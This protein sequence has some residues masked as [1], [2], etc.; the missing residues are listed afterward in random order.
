MS[1]EGKSTFSRVAVG[2]ILLT[3]LGAGYRWSSNRCVSFW[4]RHGAVIPECPDGEVRPVGQLDAWGLGRGKSGGVRVMAWGHYTSSR[5]DSDLT[6]PLRLSSVE[7]FVVDATG[8][9]LPL[10]PPKEWTRQDEGRAM[11]AGLVL[12]VDLHDGHHTLRAKL[13]TDLGPTTV[14]SPLSLFAP[15]R[16]HVVTDRPLYQPGDVVK[17]R[18]VAFRARD[19]APLE[20]RPGDFRVTSPEGELLLSESATSAR[21]GIAAGSF[22]LDRGAVSGRWRVQWHSGEQEGVAE[23][24]VKPFTLPRFRIDANASAPF[25]RPNDTPKL[26]GRVVY[27]SGAPVA[28]APIE[29]TW[30]VDGA[31]PP[32]RSWMERDLPKTAKADALG[33]FALTLPR[34]PGDLVGEATLYAALV[35]R[36]PNGDRIEGSAAFKLSRDGIHVETVTE[37]QDGLV[38]GFDNRLFV[39]ATTPDGSP[40]P[41]AAVRVRKAWDKK[42]KG[43][44]AN[45]DEDGVARLQLDPGPAVNI[46]VPPLPW[47]PPP[48]VPLVQR[49]EVN[50]TLQGD[51]PATLAD[52]R[53]LDGW[54]GAVGGCVRFATEQG[55]VSGW[56]LRVGA[57]GEVIAAQPTDGELSPLSKCLSETIRRQRLPAGKERLLNTS[58]TL[59]GSKLPTLSSDVVSEF[60]ASDRLTGALEEALLE[61][62]GCL[63]Q[64]TPEGRIARVFTLALDVAGKLTV[65]VGREGSEQGELPAIAEASSA[66]IEGKVKAMQLEPLTPEE[67]RAQPALVV[68]RIGMN[69]PQGEGEAAR[70][71]A[72]TMLGHELEV[73]ATQGGHEV[74]RTTLRMSPGTVPPLRIRTEPV[75][76]KPGETVTIQLF[77]GPEAGDMVLPDEVWVSDAAGSRT[78]VKFDKESKKAVWQSGA[79][80]SGWRS[81]SAAVGG[82]RFNSESLFFIATE[83]HFDVALKSDRPTYKPG[84]RARIAVSTKFGGQG[85]PAAVG[86]FGVDASMRQLAA[87]TGTD[88]QEQLQPEVAM[89]GKAFDLFD[90]RAMAL[91]RIRGQAAAAATVTRVASRPDLP[92]IDVQVSS[93][94]RST[95]DPNEKLTGAFYEVLTQ[96]Q[97]EVVRWELEAP[98]AEKMKP[99]TLARLW[100]R[101]RDSVKAGGKPVEDAYGRPLRL[102]QLP[103]DL[104]SLT[105]PSLLVTHGTRMP[106]DV[107][108]WTAWVA[109]EKP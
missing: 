103:A 100:S 42:D 53:A 99:A 92:P 102:S 28:S 82:G 55:Q 16:I 33:A 60:G 1:A 68:A 88:A 59:D 90:G 91:G 47:R 41:G 54:L 13:V 71:R 48:P 51:E 72:T 7:L 15:A 38:E 24:D 69:V 22:P 6:T 50:D 67:G 56:V 21:W 52:Q 89:R 80:E 18:A 32:P 81:V 44:E 9:E 77:R 34:I 98:A 73:V 4:L 2:L 75:V 101:A 109:K 106:E 49:G 78:K 27:A 105:E 85:V 10:K 40:L 11:T 19:M 8:K 12:P 45:A 35:A 107:E 5:S 94:G 37:L 86:L 76:A 20:Q 58:W 87:L 64:S 30:R 57:G 96:L 3:G 79:G 83:G 26:T 108:S 84:E 14:D 66:C 29:L 65:H 17:F 25:F 61:A 93:S 39:R 70:P 31:W 46:V 95:F 36:D 104:L 43:I 97:R 63:S 62:R 74:G 23:F